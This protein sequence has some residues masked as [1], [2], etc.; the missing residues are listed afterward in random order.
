MG[1]TARTGSTPTVLTGGTTPSLRAVVLAH[2][3]HTSGELSALL[4]GRPTP[5]QLSRLRDQRSLLGLRIVR[6]GYMYPA[7]QF[8]AD[9]RRIDPRVVKVNQLVLAAMSP[10]DAMLWWLSAPPNR[11]TPA[12]LLADASLEAV[13]KQI[14][15]V[16]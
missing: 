9:R 10:D 1:P 8:D 2:P 7:F 4:A 11:C 13:L 12:D 16:I 14:P 5:H 3:H 15:D 6:R